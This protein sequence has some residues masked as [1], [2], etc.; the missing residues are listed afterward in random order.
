[1]RC[2]RQRAGIVGGDDW[3]GI[4]NL[5]SRPGRTG[6]SIIGTRGNDDTRL[7]HQGAVSSLPCEKRRHIL[8]MAD[9]YDTV[10]KGTTPI[11]ISYRF[12]ASN[13]RFEV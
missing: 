10:G 4:K 12:P 8:Y 13:S 3:D 7:M 5:A 11:P 2:S 6:D 1:M 9:F